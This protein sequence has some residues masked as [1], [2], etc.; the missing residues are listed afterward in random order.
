[1]IIHFFKGVY[2]WLDRPGQ[3]EPDLSSWTKGLEL[4]EIQK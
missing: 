4:I 1:M 3:A 2:P